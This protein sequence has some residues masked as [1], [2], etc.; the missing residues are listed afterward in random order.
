MATLASTRGGRAIMAGLVGAATVTA[1]NELGRRTIAG[2]PRAE[3]LGVRAVGPL[4]RAAG[5]RPS[6]R[7]AFLLA[8][9]GEV[10]SNG[11]YY[12]LPALT[13]RP[14]ATGIALG[15]LAGLG[16]VA[17]P[18]RLGLGRWPTRRTARTR[19]LTVAWYL[20]AGVAAGLVARRAAARR[21]MHDG[22]FA[23]HGEPSA[24]HGDRMPLG[25]DEPGA[26]L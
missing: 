7:Q 9:A 25:A 22:A 11:A 26:G 1:L 13:R 4:A 19:A 12:A 6:R 21:V 17:L 18:P 16:A 15:A 5:A 3:L 8:L 2:A 10:L 23:E 24:E 20:A 14:L